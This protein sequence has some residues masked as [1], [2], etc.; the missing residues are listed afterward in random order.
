MRYG[1][2]AADFKARG[3]VPWTPGY[4]E[5]KW[6]TISKVIADSNFDAVIGSDH[7]GYRI[8]ER[9]VELPWLLSR[10]PKGGQFLLDAGSALNFESIVCHPRIAEKKLFIST[11]APEGQAF[12][13]RGVSYVFE[14]IRD[15]CFREEYFDCIACI[16]TLE[17]VGLDNAFLYT[18]D[19]SKREFDKSSYLAFMDVLRSRLKNGGRLYVSFPYG[20][21]KNHGWFQV[22]DGAMIDSLI[23][24]FNPASISETIFMY[25]NDRWYKATRDEAENAVCYDIN[26]DKTYA[27]DYCA[28]SRAVVCLELVR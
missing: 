1:Q 25:G 18:K 23:R 5:Y 21:A 9:I 14:D 28:F 26:V 24:R 17:H 12:W 22:F 11:L 6:R 19:T 4:H 20:Q 3:C 8:D 27:P 13:S 2:L 7:Y 10:L 16:S 15:T